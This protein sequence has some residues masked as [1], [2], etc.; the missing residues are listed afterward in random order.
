MAV[1][2]HDSIGFL[3]GI[4]L[5][6]MTARDTNSRRRRELRRVERLTFLYD[7]HHYRNGAL[8][9]RAAPH[10]RHATTYT[11]PTNRE[12]TRA[13]VAG[14]TRDSQAG[15][16]RSR[17]G[18]WFDAGGLD[19][20]ISAEE[21]KP[22]SVDVRRHFGLEYPELMPCVLGWKPLACAPKTDGQRHGDASLC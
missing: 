16:N 10:S 14:I 20:H 9:M 21:S 15:A 2:R 3:L 13:K 19:I 4:V 17:G 5:S 11:S 22:T 7:S 12:F 8:V 18:V 1:G 6:W